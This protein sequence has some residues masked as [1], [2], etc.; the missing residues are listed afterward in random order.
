MKVTL[1]QRLKNNK[2]SLYLEYYHKG[3]REYEYLE[4]YL[5]PEPIKGKLPP[6]QKE[7]N[8][9]NLALADA[10]RSKR[11]V[12][13]QNGVYGFQDLGKLKA[14]FNNYIDLLAQERKSSKGNYDNWYS[15]SKHLRKFS[16]HD[17][18]FGQID[19]KW[20][21]S[22]KRY[23]D[24]EA[25]SP[26]GKSLS[27]NTKES[28]FNKIKAA[29]KQAQKDEIISRNPGLDVPGFQPEDSERE[30]LT[31]DELQ[32]MVNT[33]CDVDVLKRAFLFSCLSGLRWSDV[34][35]LSWS[36]IQHSNEIGYYV[37]F[38][39]QKTGS[40]ETLPISDKAYDLLGER[41]ESKERAFIG[42]K[43]SAWNNLKL[44]Q[45]ANKA[46]ITKT[47]TFHV[48]RHTYATLLFTFGADI[49][50]VQKM[51]GHKHLKTT[52]V[53]TKV[54]DAKKTEAANMI[55]LKF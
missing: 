44:Q 35:K 40:V 36:E 45:W 6:E 11:N 24:K 8:K 20:L 49:Y 22:F 26:S 41:G 23:L 38:T 29:L 47:V 21:E 1:R 43:Y 4:L 48:A 32:S 16:K 14:S 54:I 46:G 10:I 7:Q 55:K 37:R 31:F 25:V 52:A 13:I 18:L 33:P 19:K 50:T 12:E 28:Y 39:Q 30:F 51:L 27:E 9:I 42:L 17:V 15:M 5:I 34:N 2:I 3:K 53:Y